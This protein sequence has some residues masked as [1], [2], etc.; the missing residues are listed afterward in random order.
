MGILKSTSR[1]FGGLLMLALSSTASHAV[2]ILHFEDDVAGTSVVPGALGSL[3][4]SGSTTFTNSTSTFNTLL[5]SNSYDLVIFGE[6]NNNPFSDVS[7]AMGTYLSGGGKVLGTTWRT[8][9]FKTFMGAASRTGVNDATLDTDG[10]AIF[11]GLGAVIDLVNPGWGV[12]SSGWSGDVGSVEIGALAG[13]AAAILGNA[14]NTLLLGPLFDTYADADGQLFVANSI[15]FLLNGATV[16]E[17]SVLALLAG[18]LGL[19]G[20]RARRNA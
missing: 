2:S 19:L 8:D 5:G 10:H 17:P 7:G 1:L 15:D 14:G 6:Q 9:D 18:A 3:G 13:G 11:A 4:L 20:F 12:Y 16:A